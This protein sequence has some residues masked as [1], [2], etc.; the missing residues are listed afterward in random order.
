METC[1]LRL[2]EINIQSTP[3]SYKGL[4]NMFDREARNN[5][6]AQQDILNQL[7]LWDAL[8]CFCV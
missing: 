3:I 2:M 8:M 1:N 4:N 5:F 6:M 7:A